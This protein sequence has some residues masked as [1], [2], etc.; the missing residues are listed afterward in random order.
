M[1]R[2]FVYKSYTADDGSVFQTRVDADHA[3]DANRGWGSAIPGGPLI[4][5]GLRERFVLG[6]SPATGRQGRA[7][8]G[9]STSLIWQGVAT[10]FNVE[11]N[12]GTIDTMVIIALRGERREVSH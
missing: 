4:P 5:R 9:S 6:I 7:R 3:T 10:T 12:D 8:I 1:P 2:G 11:A